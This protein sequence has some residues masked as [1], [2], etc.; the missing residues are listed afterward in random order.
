MAWSP[1]SSTSGIGR[2]LEYLGPGVVRDIPAARRRSFLRR[3][4]L[5]LPITPG[6]QP[7]AGVD[8]RHGGDFA[9]RQHIIADRDLFQP[10]RRDHPLVDPLEP[11]ADQDDA[12]PGGERLDPRAAS[13]ARRAGDIRS[14]GRSSCATASRARAST[15]AFITMPGP[16][17]AGVSSTVRC[18]SV[19]KLRISAMSSDPG[20]GRQRLAGEAYAER[21]RKHLGK[22]GQARWRATSQLF[23]ARAVPARHRHGLP[24]TTTTI[25]P[26]P[27]STVG[28]VASLNG[29]NRSCRLASGRTSIR[30]PAPKLCTATTVPSAV[31]GRIDRRKP[32]QVG[33]IELVGLFGLRQAL[34]WHIEL[35]VDQSLARRRGRAMPASVATK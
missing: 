11:A 20:A 9:A 29:S 14:R 1:E 22:D 21:S 13:A 4:R 8:Q 35:H 7:Y 10:A 17:P 31:A 28:T 30:S 15:S 23:V 3:S 34:A 32:D 26:A 16:P 18:L 19:A 24:A 33:V 2:P 12:G 25:R 27:R 5:S 6:Q